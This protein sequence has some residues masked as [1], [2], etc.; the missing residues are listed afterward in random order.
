MKRITLITIFLII[1]IVGFDIQSSFADKTKTSGTTVS[2][3][4]GEYYLSLSGIVAPYASVILISNDNYLR[5][6]VADSKG[7]FSLNEVLVNS[8]F[9]QFCLEA[10]DFKRLGDSYTCFSIDPIF[11]DRTINNIF[12]PPPLGLF[13]AQIKAGGQADMFGYSMPT[14]LVTI[15]FTSGQAY[16]V[17]ADQF[18][19][20]ENKV[21]IPNA[22]KYQLYAQAQLGN[23][24][25]LKP[26]RTKALQA[27]SIPE[28][29]QNGFSKILQAIINFFT[30]LP[31]GPLWIG[32]PL[33]ILIFIL[34][35]KLFP[36]V[37]LFKTKPLFFSQDR[38]NAHLLHHAWFIGY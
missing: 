25:S 9:S 20:Y 12:L 24:S 4:I 15:H 2:A 7:N 19:Y 31:L 35:R 3:S 6:T 29:L 28:Q 10:I 1:C 17:T 36:Q 30:S 22:G 37:Q 16:K 13:R 18:G 11:A 21:T 8:G 27:L 34:L 32:I 23:L 14:A 33:L 5:S 26:D 38:N